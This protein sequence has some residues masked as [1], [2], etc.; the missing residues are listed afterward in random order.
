MNFSIYSQLLF[1]MPTSSM[2]SLEIHILALR[3]V[4]LILYVNQK[5]KEPLAEK[6]MG[7]FFIGV[8][9]NI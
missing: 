5:I 3:T 1:A 6:L 9:R 2:G 8:G 7:F 4:I